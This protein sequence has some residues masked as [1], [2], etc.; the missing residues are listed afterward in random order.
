MTP[1]QRTLI[2]FIII[3]VGLGTIIDTQ[4]SYQQTSLGVRVASNLS[5]SNTTNQQ[6]QETTNSSNSKAELV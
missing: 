5:T 2:A 4:Q 1:L 6:T 3:N